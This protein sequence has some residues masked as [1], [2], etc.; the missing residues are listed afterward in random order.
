MKRVVL[1]LGWTALS[2]VVS[3]AQVAANANSGY[4]TKEGRD[5]VASTLGAPER[6]KTQQPEALATA[7]NLKAGMTVADIGTGIGYMLPYLSKGVGRAGKVLAEDIQTDFLD[8]VK[9]RI[10][11][12]KL[13]NVT[14]ILG[15]ETDPKLPAGAVDLELVLDVYHHFDYPDKMLAALGAALKPGGRLV[16]AEYYPWASTPGHIRLDRDDVIKEIEGYGWKLAAR[17]DHLNE[18]QYMLTFTKK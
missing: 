3:W 16:I 11:A 17:N 13:S 1:I 6:D 9:Q 10:A 2:C 7:L 12:S 15:T 14:T 4:K 8:A 18:R 5:K